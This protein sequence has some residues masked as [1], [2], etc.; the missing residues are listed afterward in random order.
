MR[1][2]K[3]GGERGLVGVP[4]GGGKVLARNMAGATVDDE[5]GGCWMGGW[6]C[7]GDNGLRGGLWRREVVMEGRWAL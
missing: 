3:Q 1:G 2:G 4:G 7:G 6:H 5:A